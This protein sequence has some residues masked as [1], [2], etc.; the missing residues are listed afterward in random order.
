VDTSEVK[1]TIKDELIAVLGDRYDEQRV[2]T[3]MEQLGESLDV[4]E[5]IKQLTVPL[6]DKGVAEQYVLTHS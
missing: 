3:L 2:E 4:T 1:N 5:F 6:A